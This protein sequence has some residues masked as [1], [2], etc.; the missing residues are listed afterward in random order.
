MKGLIYWFEKKRVVSWVIF[1]C[2]AI[3]IFYLSSLSSFGSQGITG[4]GH[5]SIIYHIMAFFFLNFFLLFALVYGKKKK[6]IIVAIFISI[7]YGISDEIHQL[8]VPGRSSAFF[9]IMLN[10]TGIFFSTSFYII[11]LINRNNKL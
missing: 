8:F 1:F 3:S 4:T 5:L 6:F 10:N 2:I 11:S 7:L 9:D